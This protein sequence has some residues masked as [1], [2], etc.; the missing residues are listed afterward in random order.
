MNIDEYKDHDTDNA[1][2]AADG[3]AATAGGKSWKEG[4][5]TALELQKKQFKPV[6]I[7]VPNLIPEGMTI[8]AGKPKVGKSW[9]AL[10]V[11]MAAA[12]ENRFVLGDK[13]PVH[14]DVLYLALE[15]NQRRLK[16]RL[17][18]I[19][20]GQGIWSPRLA[21]HTEWRRLNEGGLE[22]IEAWCKSVEEPRLIWIDTLAKVRPLSSRNEPAYDRDYRA[23]EGLQK[24][25]GQYPGLAIV[26]NHHLRKM[27]SEDDAFDDVSGTLGLTGA[28]D[29]IIVI[30]RHAGMMRLC[31]RG[32]DIE[33]G[34]FAAE[35]NRNTCRWRLVGDA[36]EV[37][38]SKEQQA[39]RAALK[40]APPEGMALA[41]IKDATGRHDGAALKSLLFKMKQAGDIASPR[42]GRFLLP[43]NGSDQ[44]SMVNTGQRQPVDLFFDDNNLIDKGFCAEDDEGQRGQRDS[45]CQ[46]DEPTPKMPLTSLTRGDHPTQHIDISNE[47]P[48]KKV[49]GA[50]FTT[51]DLLTNDGNPQLHDTIDG[52]RRCLIPECDHEWHRRGHEALAAQHGQAVADRALRRRIAE[53]LEELTG[54]PPS[55]EDVERDCERIMQMAQVA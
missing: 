12:D 27:S 50:P 44:R 53:Q 14:G 45:K 35:F 19:A 33:E 54:K 39:I 49:N 16:K 9:L 24:L 4:L 23:I 46:D 40:G 17:D 3:K 38:R 26:I 25:A 42:R 41:D 20:Q 43:E 52:S 37:F 34:E 11:C 5:I 31:V 32:R 55:P 48:T 15:D 6:R 1:Q 51:V 36:T 22:D 7:I 28:A 30:K 2:H 18:K 10:D 47:L 13:R 29:T 8:L 21:L